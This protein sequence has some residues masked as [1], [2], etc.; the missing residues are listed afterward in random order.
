MVIYNESTQV[1]RNIW[2][3]VSWIEPLHRQDGTEFVEMT[4]DL[5]IEK[6]Y[7]MQAGKT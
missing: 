5:Y 6:A 3:S 7:L 1:D 4:S 2:V